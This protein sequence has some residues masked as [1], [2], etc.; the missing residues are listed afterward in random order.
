[1][2]A[3]ATVRLIWDLAG[4]ALVEAVGIA[5]RRWWLALALALIIV[6]AMLWLDRPLALWFFAL[7][8]QDKVAFAAINE[9]G[10]SGWMFAVAGLVL[11]VAAWRRRADWVVRAAFVMGSV[12]L[13]GLVVNVVKVVVARARPRLL[14]AD[15]TYGVHGFDIDAHWNSFPSGHS[16]AIAAFAAALGLIWPRWRFVFL[17]LAVLPA[18]AR[19][20]MANHFAA[21]VI[22]GYAT[23]VLVA[24]ALARAMSKRNIG[25][26]KA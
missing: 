23:G 9:V 17:A 25:P 18:A 11:V 6:A 21:D 15:G 2:S 3:A 14:I 13:G 1:M 26:I 16:Q 22:A 20:V 24:F 8:A 7:P 19:M 12:A 5:A 10:R 4:D